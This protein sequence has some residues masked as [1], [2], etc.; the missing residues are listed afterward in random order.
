MRRRLLRLLAT[1]IALGV[2][3]L[4]SQAC[5]TGCD[6]E[7]VN[8]AVAFIDEHQACETDN[9]CVNI[10]DFCEELPGGWCGQ[11]LMNRTGAESLDW[12]ALSLELRACAPDSCTTCDGLLVPT[13]SG[14]VCSQR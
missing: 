11:Q 3:A 14:G 7:V 12:H 6:A 1:G 9:D 4:L 2:A 13:C 5:S 10:S 8:R